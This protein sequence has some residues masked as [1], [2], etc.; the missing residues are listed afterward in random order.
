MGQ[1]TAPLGLRA[2]ACFPCA[3]VRHHN[4][5]LFLLSLSTKIHMFLTMVVSCVHLIWG[6]THTVSEALIC[7]V[8]S[9]AS[10]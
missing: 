5:K 3:P 6:D 4:S 1:S 8:A 2:Q 10:W 9:Q 7:N